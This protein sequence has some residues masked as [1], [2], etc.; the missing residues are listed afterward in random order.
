MT[1]SEWW[2]A[3]DPRALIDW[4]FFDAQASDRKLR[5]F[6]VAGCEPLRRFVGDPRILAALDSAEAFA[7]GH[8]DAVAM[9]AIHEN[10]WRDYRTRHDTNYEAF[11]TKDRVVEASCL[12]PTAQDPHRDRDRYRLDDDA[13]YAL[14]LARFIDHPDPRGP[15][16][17]R[18]VRLLHDIFG[19]LPF[20]DAAVHPSGLTSD[21][22]RAARGIYEEKAFDRM[23]IPADASKTRAATA[24]TC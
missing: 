8:I 5:L 19:L 23:P 3:T 12:Y 16:F 24:T 9:A 17:P 6:S 2:A 11:S 1:E 7:D 22:L 10:A 4:L 21:V 20:R 14:I 15:S 18:L 13:P